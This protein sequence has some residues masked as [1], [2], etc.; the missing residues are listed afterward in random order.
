MKKLKFLALVGIMMTATPIFI[1]CGDEEDD[2]QPIS[3]NLEKQSSNTYNDSTYIDVIA[4]EATDVTSTSAIISGYINNNESQAILDIGIIYMEQNEA[5]MMGSYEMTLYGKK[6]TASSFDSG[7]NNR[8]TVHITDLKPGTTYCYFAFAGQKYF[9]RMR[10]FTTL[11]YCPDSNHPHMIDLGLS[12]GTKWAC[13]NVGANPYYTEWSDYAWGEVEMKRN[14]TRE[15][16]TY[17]NCFTG[18]YFNIGSDIAGTSYDAATANWGDSWRMPTKEQ[19]QELI[20]NCS[21]EWTITKGVYRQMAT[22][23]SG[24]FIFFPVAETSGKYWSST[25]D[26]RYRNC[27]Y[28]LYFHLNDEGAYWGDY[29]FREYGFAV[30]PVAE[31]SASLS[32]VKKEM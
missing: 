14:Y 9:I 27:A 15:N 5:F 31:S 26:E 25:L 17:Y 19:W 1:A 4:E 2:E 23:P 22:G 6:V 18:E 29:G 20:N 30:R 24:G 7:S 16:Y 11:D 28:Y 32:N 10:D 21:W 12:S 3:R 13:C 8:F